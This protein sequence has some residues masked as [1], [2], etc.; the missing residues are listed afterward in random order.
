MT[1]VTGAVDP[2]LA[3]HEPSALDLFSVH[4]NGQRRERVAG[5]QAKTKKP[6]GRLSETLLESR[7]EPM[8]NFPIDADSGHQ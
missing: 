7:I 2:D 3:G 4:P 6:E 8:D 5:K 1:T